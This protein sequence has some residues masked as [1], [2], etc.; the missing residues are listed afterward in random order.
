MGRDIAFETPLGSIAGWRANPVEAPRGA[1][2]VV[3]EIFGVNAHRRW[4][5][6]SSIRSS[7]GS[8]WAMT[9]PGSPGVASWSR[10]WGSTRPSRSSIPRHNCCAAKD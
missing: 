1:L 8:N 4:R 3:Q 7:A 10:P 2:V 5:R 6:P 9:K